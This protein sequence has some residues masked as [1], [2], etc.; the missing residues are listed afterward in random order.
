VSAPPVSGEARARLLAA[1]DSFGWPHAGADAL[2]RY[3]AAVWEENRRVNLTGAASLDAALD[4]LAIDALPVVRAWDVS[5]GPPR[6][7]IDLGTGNGLP[8][9]AVALAWP[10]CRTLLVERR[11]KKAHAVAR[12]LAAAGVPNAEVLACDG[13]ELLR[14]R[15][16]L[17]ARVDLVTVRAVG[18]LAPTTK[19]AA[20]WLAPRGRL[21]HWKPAPLDEA[22]RAAG[23]AA[24]KKGGLVPLEDVVFRVPGATADRRLVIYQR[25]P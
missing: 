9:V 21:V 22:E 7:A 17:R 12:C 6:A 18:D 14:L 25:S 24:A 8:G 20:P 4:V 16:D 19:E 11:A 15:P 3:V 10:A 1:A 13:R 23:D 2:L 5:R